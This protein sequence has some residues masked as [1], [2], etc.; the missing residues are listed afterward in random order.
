MRN[1]L[2]L[3][4]SAI[5]LIPFLL[6]LFIKEIPND[7][8]PSLEGTQIIYK[9]TEALQSF[10]SAMNNL[11][12]I[13]LSIKNPYFRN[14][15]DLIFNILNFDKILIRTGK[16]NG[17]N[18]SDGDLMKIQFDPIN[19]AKNKE[20]F[21]E[22]K[23]LDTKDNEAFE[24]F[25]TSKKTAWIG[26]LYINSQKQDSNL[27]FFTYHKSTNIFVNSMEIFI[28]LFRRL[29]A[30]LPFALFYLSLVVGLAG[31]LFFSKEN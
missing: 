6:T 24:V 20:F 15:K 8:Q 17:A 31:Y 4:I 1:Y 7:V 2:L 29:F 18:I 10:K 26:N 22:L 27:S 21:L 14:R 12:G 28:Q 5:F 25:L 19:D 16:I 30:D 23:A 9:D 11:S 3:F 13:G